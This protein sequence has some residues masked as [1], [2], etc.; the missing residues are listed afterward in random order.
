VAARPWPVRGELLLPHGSGASRVGA[1]RAPLP[2]DSMDLTV[3]REESSAHSDGGREIPCG[4][5]REAEGGGKSLFKR[6]PQKLAPIS[7]S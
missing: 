6:A 3:G 1:R 2:Q 5:V 4:G 7:T